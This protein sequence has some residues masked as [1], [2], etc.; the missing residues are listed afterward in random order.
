MSIIQQGIQTLLYSGELVAI[1]VFT[2]I[3]A[4]VFGILQQIQIFGKETN[5]TKKYNLLIAIVFGA[6][7]IIPHYIAKG[8]QYDVIP[9][10]QK[11]LPQTMLI[12]IAV[13]SVLILLG[14]LGM[15]GILNEQKNSWFKPIVALIAVGIIIYIF[16]GASGFWWRLPYWFTPDLIA[17]ALAL[18]VFGVI[19]WFVM[20]PEES[21]GGNS[22]NTPKSPPVE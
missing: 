1:L 17:A 8:S 6:L 18:L 20:G 15:N 2:L 11:A 16:A 19:V 7:T 21:S 10:I 4:I 13:L 12:I 22:S 5:E 14:L 3:F 9:I